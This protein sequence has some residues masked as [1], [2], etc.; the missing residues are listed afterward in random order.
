MNP[1]LAMIKLVV[2][3]RQDGKR[4]V[5]WQRAFLGV[6]CL[7][8]A[9]ETSA[10]LLHFRRGGSFEDAL[11]FVIAFGLAVSVVLLGLFYWMLLPVDR[12]PL[13]NQPSATSDDGGR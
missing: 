5:S 10:F 3:G 8:T 12:L 11:P 2:V 7:N 9:G 1:V 4:V 13:M 6:A